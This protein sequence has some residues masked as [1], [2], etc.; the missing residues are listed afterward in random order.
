M[1]K[2]FLFL[3]PALLLSTVGFAQKNIAASKVPQAVQQA[4]NAR[5]AGAH[6]IDW[7]MHGNNYEAEVEQK[8]R[9]DI[10]LLLDANGN[11]LA[12]KYEIKD[13]KLPDAVQHT[14]NAKYSGYHVDDVERVVRNGKTYYQVELD[15]LM[16]EDLHIVFSEDGTEQQIAYWH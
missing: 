3:S 15:A 11:I 8:G 14:I 7:E 16:K 6:D 4:V 12:E 2:L 9:E 13:K 10:Y 5:Y 1:N